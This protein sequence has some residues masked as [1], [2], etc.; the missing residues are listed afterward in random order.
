M[1]SPPSCLW[2]RGEQGAAYP[3]GLLWSKSVGKAFLGMPP[4]GLRIAHTLAHVSPTSPEPSLEGK[5]ATSL[6][7]SLP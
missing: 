3:E 7:F 2:D 1:P 4:K 5:A 6:T